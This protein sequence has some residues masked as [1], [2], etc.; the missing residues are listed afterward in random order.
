MLKRCVTYSGLR[1]LDY[2]T[3]ERRVSGVAK[4]RILDAVRVKK[5]RRFLSPIIEKEFTIERLAGGTYNRIV[6]IT[7]QRC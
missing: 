3:P 5:L 4:S 2:R 1:S 6:A 7:G